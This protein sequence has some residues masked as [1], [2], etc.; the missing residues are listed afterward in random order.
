MF[1]PPSSIVITGEKS[2]EQFERE[3][4]Q[5]ELNARL[6]KE[7]CEVDGT[8]QLIQR[9]ADISH[10]NEVEAT[11]H[12]WERARAWEP[13]NRSAFYQQAPC[14]RRHLEM[15]IGLNNPPQL[16]Q[17]ARLFSKVTNRCIARL[18]R[19]GAD[20]SFPSPSSADLIQRAPRRLRCG[21][22]GARR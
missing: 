1:A 22:R 7:L 19:R 6:P 5:R 18:W 13:N 21:T 10:L 14:N 15:R 8:S 2:R 12:F 4:Q 11:Y 20:Q 3:K 16:T 17:H 9:I